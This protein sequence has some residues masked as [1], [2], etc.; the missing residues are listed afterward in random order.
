MKQTNITTSFANGEISPQL[1]GRVDI[2][3]YRRSAGRLKNWL[4]RP[5]GNARNRTG[6]KFIGETKTSA[7]ASR[8][9]DFVFSATQSYAIEAGDEYFRYITDEGY[10]Y[11]GSTIVTTTTPYQDT[12]I[13][14]LQ[15]AQ[16]AD[17]LYLVHPS[18]A[19]R[20]LVR[21][22]ATTWTLS[23]LV[24]VKAPFLDQNTTAV[25]L[26]PSATSGTVTVTASADTFLAGHVGTTWQHVS[27][28]TTG[29][30][31]ITAVGSATSATA[32]VVDT[33]VASAS[34]K[35]SEAAWSSVRG[36][37]TTIT[38]H[39]NRLV[40]AGTTTE[41][42]RGWASDIGVYDSFSI[43]GTEDEKGFDFDLPTREY[44]KILWMTSG[45]N[46]AVGTSGGEFI[47]SS[48]NGTILTPVNRNAKQQTAYGSEAISVRTFGAYSYFVQRTARKLR[49]FSFSWEADQYKA[50]DMTI[51]SEHITKTG[52]KDIA[53]QK[54]QDSIIFCVL[55]D[56][57]IAAFTRET[58]QNVAAWSTIETDGIVEAICAIPRETGDDDVYVIVKRTI[59]GVAKR[60]V[61]LFTQYKE[62]NIIESVFLDSCLTYDGFAL[63][64]GK[65]LTLSAITGTGV[66]ATASSA[67]F[68]A[69][70]V[71]RTIKAVD[72]NKNIVGKA[73]IVGYTDSTHVTV[74]IRIDFE[75]LA[76]SGGLWGIGVLTI[77]GL[78][79]L[80]GKSVYALADG[81]FK[82]T[83]ETVAS[84]AIT[85]D[86]DACYVTVG[87]LYESEMQLVPLADGSEI[88]TAISK[89]SRVP[90]VGLLVHETQGI[91]VGDTVTQNEVFLR[92]AD[93]PLG[94]PEELKTG[95]F[96]VATGNEWMDV[97]QVTVKQSKPLP[98]NILAIVQYSD[99]GEI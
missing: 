92:N 18:Y 70:M 47:V 98:A 40:F 77:S 12:D 13:F 27:G 95:S 6:L 33:V 43:G 8:L 44:N 68:S 26:T 86:Y 16:S 74:D 88:G 61:E 54:N 9:I 84:G 42:Q 76:I 45:E 63:T 52:I 14:S 22:N 72:A 31:K 81:A 56:G 53:F 73:K 91:T 64:A 96:R 24:F 36:Y 90:L 87:L 30:F 23:E 60:Y 4:V 65:T 34:T 46:L 3:Q 11:S 82:D 15:Y 99:T 39:Q 38:F 10:V 83:A 67:S 94:Q 51:L 28:S 62:G 5:Y 57:K 2:D 48:G 21:G 17:V 7:K 78:S 59:G 41:P 58:E 97:C 55:N 35:W 25:T 37:P 20:K 49:E 93:T 71:G 32:T 69:P 1:F 66:T 19:P 80:E 50:G 29:T 79:H 75:A 85:R 89:K